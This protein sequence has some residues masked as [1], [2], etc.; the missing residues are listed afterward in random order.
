MI[1]LPF[2]SLHVRCCVLQSCTQFKCW[3][4]QFQSHRFVPCKNYQLGI[5]NKNCWLMSVIN[6]NLAFTIPNSYIVW[7]FWSLN[8]NYMKIKETLRP[9]WYSLFQNVNRYL[10]I[11]IPWVCMKETGFATIHLFSTVDCWY[12]HMQDEKIVLLV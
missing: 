6:I 5:Q 10:F 8:N 1:A 7:A 3:L 9:L 2:S 12:E 11:S 4:F